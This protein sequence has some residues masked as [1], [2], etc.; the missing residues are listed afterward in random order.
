MF[1][2]NVH[3]HLFVRLIYIYEIHKLLYL[4]NRYL[5]PSTSR[6]HTFRH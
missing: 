6:N 2:V 5:N 3:L 1:V 4:I